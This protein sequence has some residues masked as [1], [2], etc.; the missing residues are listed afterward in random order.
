[1]FI[2]SSENCTHPKILNGLYIPFP[3]PRHFTFLQFNVP[4]KVPHPLSDTFHFPRKVDIRGDIR[5]W[6]VKSI[7]TL[8]RFIQNL[9]G[10]LLRMFIRLTRHPLLYSSSC[11]ATSTSPCTF[12][13]SLMQL[14]S[15]ESCA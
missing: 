2:L 15:P 3:I 10:N 8:L 5:G 12:P 6:H 13:S 9:Q 11:L 1:M 4:F 14:R 7:F